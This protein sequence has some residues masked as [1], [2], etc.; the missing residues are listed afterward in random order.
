MMKVLF[1]LLIFQFLSQLSYAEWVKEMENPNLFQGDIVL[2]PEDRNPDGSIKFAIMKGGRWPNAE[3]P[4]SIH[5]SLMNEPKALQ[6]IKDAIAE[7][8]KYTCIRFKKRTT[9]SSYINLYNGIGC[10]SPVGYKAGR[11]NDVSIGKG[12]WTKG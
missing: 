10:N 4:Y 1:G 8:H 9:E 7:Y 5:R 3:V 12:C 6:A 11:V 2:D